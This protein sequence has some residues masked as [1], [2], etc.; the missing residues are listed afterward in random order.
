MKR[1]DLILI[2][3]FLFAFKGHSQL[4]K[5]E[6]DSYKKEIILAAFSEANDFSRLGLKWGMNMYEAEG[7]LKNLKISGKNELAARG[8][9]FG[10]LDS[11]F[12]LS[13]KNGKLNQITNLRFLKEGSSKAD[14]QEAYFMYLNEIHKFLNP[15]NRVKE[16]GVRSFYDSKP[17]AKD[18]W[19]YNGGES[20][21]ILMLQTSENT[22]KSVSQGVSFTGTY[23]SDVILLT[24]PE[25]FISNIGVEATNIFY[26]K[27][28]S[29]SISDELKS[30]LGL[31]VNQSSVRSKKYSSIQKQF[32]SSDFKGSKYVGKI[33]F[34]S[35]VRSTPLKSNTSLSSKTIM[36]I[37][38]YHKIVILN[39]NII[40]ENYLKV[41]VDNKVG[42]LNINY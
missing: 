23:G 30:G 36:F 7:Y 8:K 35:N 17:K 4:S 15:S 25:D 16:L 5:N 37:K 11:D 22:S 32:K 26:K 27:I 19:L 3:A 9:L 29:S 33:E 38:P 24:L 28:S 10:L 20:A 6:I 18:V 39:R 34:Y 40:S 42:W 31:V 1:S 41:R 13:F 21:L 12:I 2:F 14:L